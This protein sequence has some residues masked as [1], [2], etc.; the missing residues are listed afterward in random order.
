MTEKILVRALAPI[1]RRIQMLLSRGVITLMNSST[2]LQSVQMHFLDDAV[3]DGLEYFEP[4]GF[5]ATAPSNNREGLALFFDGDRGHG[6]VICI[7]NRQYRLR[8]LQPG[9]VALYDD[10]GQKIVLSKTGI[11]V[12]S[13]QSIRLEAPIVHCT[14]DFFCQGE[15]IDRVEKGGLSMS[16]TR[17]IYNT[18]THSDH[19]TPTKSVM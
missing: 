16:Q 11:H 13:P 15:V 9:E 7:A 6:V 1:W 2:K 17:G 18:H 14:G 19:H 3:K 10:Q 8:G 4:Y 12:T 5:T